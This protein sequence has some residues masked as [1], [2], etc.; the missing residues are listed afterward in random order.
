MTRID[1]FGRSAVF[2]AVAALGWIPWLVVVGAVVGGPAARALYL[3]AVTAFYAG[4]LARS[5]AR[6][7]S[8][9]LVVVVAGGILAAIARGLP[10]LSLGLAV[11]LGTARSGFLHRIAPAR[12][13]A[14][15]AALLVG[16]L[17]FARFL[18]GGAPHGSALALWG[19]LLVQS[20]FFL[21]GGVQ[22]LAADGRP[23][24]PFDDACARA[25]EVLERPLV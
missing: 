7:A 19:F 17:V 18:A 23:L 13:V 21:V 15:E 6:R 16:G 25:A 2:A 4:G 1:S 8:A 11:V 22:P 12:A 24:D 5:T 9:L 20:C 3:V 14:I 10:E